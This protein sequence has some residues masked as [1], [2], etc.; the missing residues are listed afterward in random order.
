[1]ADGL[2][3]MMPKPTGAIA[4]IAHRD[5]PGTG[6]L[7]LDYAGHFDRVREF[8]R[9]DPRDPASAAGQAAL[10]DAREY[11]RAELARTL[12]EQNA[13]WEAGPAALA[14]ARRL[15]DPRALAVL[16]GQQT[17]LFGGPILTLL[18]AATAVGVAAACEARLGRPVV[19]V[20]WMAAE[21]HD[22]PEADHVTLLDAGHRPTT[23]RLSSSE[24]RGVRPAEAAGTGFM[25]ANLTLGPPIQACL[26][27][28]AALLPA[29]EFRDAILDSLARCYRPEETLASA[30]AR[31]M[32]WLTRDWGLVLADPSDPRLKA[33]AAPILEGEVRR[34]PATSQAILQV[35]ARIEGRGYAPQIAARGDGANAFL[36][37]GGRWPIRRVEG[38]LVA[39]RGGALAP[40]DPAQATAAALS[41]NVA[42]RPVMQDT[43]FPTLAYIGGPAEIA[44]FAQLGPAYAAYGV[45]MPLVL[46]RAHVT[47]LEARIAE[48][49]AR[50][51][52]A[53][54][55][56]RAEAEAL[57][58]AILR[59]D[60]AAGFQARMA[61]AQ[62]AV[63][64]TF[65]DVEALVGEI[66]PTLKGPATQAAGHAR[67]QIDGLERKA[68]QALKRR[69]EDLRAQ[70]H[71]V[72]EH[73]MPGGR[74]Q[75]RVLC[76]LPFLVK[77]GRGLLDTLRAAAA[78]PGW[79]HRLVRLGPAP[80]GRP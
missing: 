54:P 77:Y 17:G 11:P 35:S 21:D 40:M 63:A 5:L 32:A 66:D 58:S 19:P 16:T 10:L 29:T 13:A 60:Q 3:R 59:Q 76:L 78:D 37:D 57:V 64:R 22:L 41:P 38:R 18:K 1:M 14:G 72:R 69:H 4:E 67:H 68:I 65:K 46:P 8:Y 61:D 79:T 49:M 25:P 56:L 43:L 44:Y 36:L 53:L 47:L 12:G 6:P 48:L 15:A 70:V 50:H 42:L 7:F 33:A 24:S 39:Q 71:R 27:E 73:L 52:L 55:Q 45:P 51:A 80:A 2:Q 31:W 20:F 34:A 23:I 28:A 9:W 74:P 30:F 62:A 26:A 75:E